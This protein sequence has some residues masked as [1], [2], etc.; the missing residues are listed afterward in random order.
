[1]KI[2]V[3]DDDRIVVHLLSAML[4]QKAHQVL[5]VFDAVQAF[6][7]AMRQ[8][9]DAV[10]LDL[11]MPGGTGFEVLKRL[12]S[13]L[14]TMLIPVIVLSATTDEQTATNVKSLGANAFLH[15]PVDPAVLCETLEKVVH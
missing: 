14:K 8:L 5:A 13:S 6:T 12:K 2:L 15:K 9:P 4:R 11:N 3:A 10:I 7:S 1:M